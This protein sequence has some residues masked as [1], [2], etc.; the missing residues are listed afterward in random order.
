[1]VCWPSAPDHMGRARFAVLLIAGLAFVTARSASAETATWEYGAWLNVGTGYESESRV[2]P[3]LNRA[4]VPGGSFLNFTPA[5]SLVRAIGAR[6]SLAFSA[7]ASLENFFNSDGRLFFG[8]SGLGELTL[9]SRGPFYG[10]IALGGE[11]FDD[12]EIETARRSGAGGY[13]SVGWG[14]SRRAME[15]TLGARQR[16]YSDLIVEDDAGIPGTYDETTTSVGAAAFGLAGRSA[17]LRGEISLLS[18]DARDPLFDSTSWYF[19]GDARLARGERWTTWASSI[20][21]RREF[22]D[23]A[24]GEDVDDYLRLGL[25][26]D[27]SLGRRQLL[28]LQYA[29]ALYGEPEGEQDDTHRIAIY[30]TSRFG[31]AVHR[32]PAPM[33]KAVALPEPDAT[34]SDGEALFRI[35]AE[36]AATVSVVGDWN[37]W[38]AGRHALQETGDG[39]WE[40]TVRI[41]PGIHQYAFVID[42]K[43]VTPPMADTTVDDGFGGRNG[44]LVIP[45]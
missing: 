40:I 43:W 2:D 41:E 5:A 26:L 30:Y 39:W 13:G 25:R 3:D 27:R 7:S 19:R 32:G 15:F 21:Q 22:D 11:Y 16:T 33:R 28:T 29:Y 38:D 8:L 20:Y 34:L 44:L 42:G 10:R 31:R 4:A 37:G 45:E 1:M 14:T 35:R 9:R 24:A 18:T 23:R 6:S 36:E 17:L 12:S